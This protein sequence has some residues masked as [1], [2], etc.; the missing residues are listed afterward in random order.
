ML[1]WI[2][3]DQDTHELKYGN[4]TASVEHVVGPWDWADEET[5][6][7]LESNRHFY[8]VQEE[9]GDWAV[10]FDR[11]LDELEDALEYQ[12]KLDNAFAPITLKRHLIEQALQPSK[13]NGNS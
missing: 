11:E 4:R 8:A 9:D 13:K 5:T 1:G 7:I 3:V 10:Y 2:Y 12:D 6:I